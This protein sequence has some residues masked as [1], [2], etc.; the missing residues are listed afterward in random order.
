[1]FVLSEVEVRT[2]IRFL[3][4]KSDLPINQNSKDLLVF[5]NTADVNLLKRFGPT[6]RIF[7]G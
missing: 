5:K 3:R 2:H 4:Y 1:M 6:F 7:A